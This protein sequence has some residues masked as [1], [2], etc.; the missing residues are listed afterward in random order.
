MITYQDKPVIVVGV[1]ERGDHVTVHYVAALGRSVTV[2]V[3][4][5]CAYTIDELETALVEAPVLA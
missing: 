1:D 4:E 2:P 3:E 5:L